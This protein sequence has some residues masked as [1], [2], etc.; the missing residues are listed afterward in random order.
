MNDMKRFSRYLIGLGFAS[1]LLSFFGKMPLISGSFDP[2]AW[3]FIAALF[4]LAAW[5]RAEAD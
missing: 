5:A 2:G 1:M 4:A 3:A